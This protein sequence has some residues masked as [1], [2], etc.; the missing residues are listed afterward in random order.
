MQHSEH[1]L[2]LFPA[3]LEM[4]AAEAI[5]VRIMNATLASNTLTNYRSPLKGVL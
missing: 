4:R 2:S 5:R 3:L 1:Q